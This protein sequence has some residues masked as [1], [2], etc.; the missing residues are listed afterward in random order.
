MKRIFNILSPNPGQGPNKKEREAGYFNI[1][2]YVFD[3]SVTSIYKVTGD[4]EIL[5][6]VQLLK[7][8]LKALFVLPKIP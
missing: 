7:C 3:E 1:R 5:D 4:R 8:L 2:F 6:T